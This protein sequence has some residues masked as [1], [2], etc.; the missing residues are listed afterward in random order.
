MAAAHVHHALAILPGDADA[1]PDGAVVFDADGRVLDVGPAARILPA[2]AGAP[3]TR[4][5]AVLLPGLVNAHTHVDL[6]WLRGKVPG[7]RGF[8]AWV[9]QLVALRRFADPDEIAAGYAEAADELRAAGTAAVGDVGRSREA[10]GAVARRGIGGWFFRELRG[11]DP[12]GGARGL[13]LLRDAEPAPAPLRTGVVPHALYTTRET[14]L[15]AVAAL[16]RERGTRLS[17]H[18]AEF[19]AERAYLRDRSGPVTPWLSTVGFDHALAPRGE[20]P[21]ACAAALGLLAPDVLTV[22]LADARRPELDQ[23]AAAGARAVLCPRSNLHIQTLLPPLLDVLA[24][25]LRPALGTD[26]LASSPSLDVLA[27]AAAL[28]ARF[29]T[30]PLRALLAMATAWG[31]DALDLPALGRLAPGATPGL[32]AVAVTGMAPRDPFAHVLG[33]PVASRRWVVESGCSRG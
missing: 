12:D 20:S 24:A 11:V 10:A 31:A 14:T 6:S 26:S 4:H 1:I 32:L 3:V 23:L 30:A 16:A 8:V 7:G 2:H 21:I 13:A 5:H 22:H 29:P 28:R 33:S 19:A 17:L 18:L 15:R 27:E 9:E 25:G